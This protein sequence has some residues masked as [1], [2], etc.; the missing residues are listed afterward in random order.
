MAD[1]TIRVTETGPTGNAVDKAADGIEHLGDEAKKASPKL[2]ELDG[3]GRAAGRGA[4][5]MGDQ[6]DKSKRDADQL[7][8]KLT[9]LKAA[10]VTLGRSLAASGGTDMAIL[11][12]FNKTTA[13]FGKTQKVGR[14]LDIDSPIVRDPLI[15]TARK[16]G[17]EGASTFAQF[18]EGGV[19]KALKSPAGLTVAGAVGVPALVTAGAAAGGAVT[20]GAGLGVAGA[21]IAGA[22]MQSQKVKD[23]W[24]KT[25]ETIKK[26]FLDATAGFEG[27]TIAAIKRVG[28]ALHTD[29]NW[30]SIFGQAEKF[31]EPVA[32]S[33]AKALG[34]AGR[35]VEH[36]VSKAMPAVVAI[37]NGIQ[38][39]GEAT[40]IAL[41]RIGDGSDGGAKALGQVFTAISD[42]IIVT[43]TWI[44]WFED[45]YDA[46]DRLVRGLGELH[47]VLG[48]LNDTINGEQISVLSGTLDHSAA[49]ARGAY[50]D[51]ENLSATMYNT[52][53]AADTLNDSFKSLLEI[54]LNQGEANLKAMQ[55]W[56]DLKKEL[57]DGKKTLDERTQ[58]GRDNV[59]ALYKQLEVLEDVREADIAAGDGTVESARAANAAYESQVEGIRQIL[60]HLGYAKSEVD[61]FIAAFLAINGK[62]VDI[63]INTFHNDYYARQGAGGTAFDAGDRLA[64]RGLD[65]RVGGPIGAAAAGGIH[66]GL[67]R[68]GEE[69][70]EYARL[71]TGTMVYPHANSMQMQAQAGQGGGTG[72]PQI[73]IALVSS[74]GGDAVTE[75]INNLIRTGRLKLKVINNRVVPA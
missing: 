43:G 49:A 71:P 2:T 14:L 64:R 30:K 66:S 22:A 29:I 67:T 28:G 9:E 3:A 47:P 69:G 55:G 5:Q 46:T 59:E 16:L 37:S 41:D 32:D 6:F 18:F 65:R 35:G 60:L 56:A 11:K 4:K 54:T 7:I 52:A 13:E 12:E 73:S 62:S 70:W 25:T 57:Q 10:S 27:P 24:A 42:I 51:F 45:A 1:V 74:G 23:E 39:M 31:V 72:G 26:D 34:A 63:S 20:G 17:E 68:V 58:A 36:L 40:E 50:D 48:F 38:E 15:K 61:A 8:R 33:I 19:L 53:D 75:V 44:G 21:G